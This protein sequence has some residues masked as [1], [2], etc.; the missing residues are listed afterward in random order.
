MLH[1]V[2]KSATELK[3]N[4]V[5]IVS[6]YHLELIVIFCEVS[7]FPAKQNWVHLRELTRQWQVKGKL[8]LG[9]KNS[10]LKHV[11]GHNMTNT[12][13]RDDFWLQGEWFHLIIMLFRAA[14]IVNLTSG[15][16]KRISITNG[17]LGIF[18]FFGKGWKH[19]IWI[20]FQNTKH[21]KGVL[22]EIAIV[23]E[24]KL[25]AKQTFP[26]KSYKQSSL[27]KWQKIQLNVKI[28]PVNFFLECQSI[29]SVELEYG[30][31]A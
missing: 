25:L 29:T 21:H 1:G 27:R 30:S 31:D 17:T 6:N 14:L 28:V 19:H 23:H 20:H 10:S 26:W 5:V 7:C 15:N 4:L 3:K 16:S 12:Q 9:R 22:D 18:F 11:A 8:E 2:E 13:Q 24:W